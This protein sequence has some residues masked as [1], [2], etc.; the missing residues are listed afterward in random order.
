MLAHKSGIS[1]GTISQY[2]TGRVKKPSESNKQKLRNIL[3]D[4]YSES[5]DSQLPRISPVQPVKQDKVVRFHKSDESLKQSFMNWL[6][7]YNVKLGIKQYQALMK[8]LD[9]DEGE[10]YEKSI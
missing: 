2:E 6:E 3:G 7:E 10:E 5:K 9:L 8:L 1:V 4:F